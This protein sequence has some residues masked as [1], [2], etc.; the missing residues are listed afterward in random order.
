MAASEVQTWITGASAF[1]GA[2]VG[3]GGTMAFLAWWLATRFSNVYK[4]MNLVESR[5]GEKIATT[6][7]LVTNK[8]DSHE[9]LDLERFGKQ[10]LAIMRIEL[11][12]Q[13][14]GKSLHSI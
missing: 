3:V 10:D 5:L 9:K 6:E 12:L 1:A 13:K 11:S 2:L 4:Q 8:I 14:N 7:K